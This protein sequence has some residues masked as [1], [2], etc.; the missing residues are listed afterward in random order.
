MS[1]A[2]RFGFVAGLVMLFAGLDLL[3]LLSHLSRL[4]GALL[5]IAGIA[6][7]AW[8]SRGAGVTGPGPAKPADNI[9]SRLIRKAT[10]GGRF[11]DAIP[12]AGV[13]V[14]AS[15][16]VFNLAL[17][18]GLYLGSNDYVALLLGAV[19]LAYNY[20]P[21]RYSVE[22]DFALL[23]GMLLFVLLV[24]PTTALE[25]TSESADTNSPLTYYFLAMPTAS[26]VRLLGVPVVSPFMDAGVPVY[27]VMQLDGPDGYPINLSIALSCSGLY[28]VAI[29]VSAFAAFVAVEYRR[30]DRVV[31]ALLIVGVALA[32]IAN[33][34]RM[35]VIV[36]VGHAWG[37]GPMQWTHNN[38]GELIFMAWVA[39][40][41][42]LMFR[43][44]GVLDRSPAKGR[45]PRRPRGRC[46]VCGETLSPTIP[47]S[48]CECGAISHSG[49]I[50]TNGMRCP[51]CGVEFGPDLDPR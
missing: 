32:W 8:A 7:L 48:R 21:A 35:T 15:V 16:A 40:F 11:R 29:F 20:V 5:I 47:A 9:A 36:L 34:L 26:L 27:N 3:I 24:I 28:S 39:A 45:K 51:S 23:F 44:F 50:L 43:R 38:I 12:A 6:V 18:D 4:W 37:A 25:F 14:L 31:A 17:K 13:C 30:F 10:F 2:R 22:R 19:L 33:I 1:P 49:C 41:W 42:Y 46:A